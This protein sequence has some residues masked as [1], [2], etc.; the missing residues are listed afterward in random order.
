MKTIALLTLL[1]LGVVV[2]W[3]VTGTIIVLTIP[4]VTIPASFSSCCSGFRRKPEERPSSKR[5][6]HRVIRGAIVPENFF[7]VRVAD[8][9]LEKVVNRFGIF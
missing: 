9:E 5:F 6:L 1:T 7:L 3:A 4:T 2:A 8:R